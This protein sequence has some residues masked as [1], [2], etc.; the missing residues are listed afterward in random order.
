MKRIP[1]CDGPEVDRLRQVR[2]DITRRYKSF[3]ALFAHFQQMEREHRQK[4]ART[5]ARTRK[6]HA[7]ATTGK[8]HGRI[9]A[10]S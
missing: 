5:Q 7:A 6:R 2:D 4:L 1:L 9:S 10:A 8:P 3:D